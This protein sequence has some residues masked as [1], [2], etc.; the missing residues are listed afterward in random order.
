MM[1]FREVGDTLEFTIS[2]AFDFDTSKAMLLQCK[3][4]QYQHQIA[5]QLHHVTSCNSC[6]VGTLALLSE[7]SH[8]EL[9]I[10][11]DKC[12]E[13]IQYLFHSGFLDR[14]FQHHSNTKTIIN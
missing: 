14:F 12:S 2:G 7:K 8:K 5:I 4:A 11:L 3:T 13:D 9:H 6:A 10:K 1:T